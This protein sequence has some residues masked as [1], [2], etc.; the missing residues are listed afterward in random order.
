VTRL[1]RLMQ[2]A[3]CA[4]RLLDA[5]VRIRPVEEIEVDVVSVECAE[6]CL[7]VLDDLV[8]TPVTW[9]DLILARRHATLRDDLH[10]GAATPE[11][12]AKNLLGAA[13]AFPVLQTAIEAVDVRG[14]EKRDAKVDGA[15]D[16]LDD[17]CVVDMAEG[18]AH[19]P[20]AESNRR[21]L[22]VGTAHAACLHWRPP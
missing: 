20:A 16:G 21:G 6:A 8:V 22:E 13:R 17:F 12:L 11:R 10:F 5:D 15:V 14:V 4:H 9:E 18:S 1:P 19:L 2:V 3:Q 7:S